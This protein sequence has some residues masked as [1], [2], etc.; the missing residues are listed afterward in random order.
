M[1][2]TVK[3]KPRSKQT[4]VKQVE[5]A[6]YEVAVHEAPAD[7]KANMA[8]QKAL[9]D[10]FEVARSRVSLVRGEGSRLKV[11]EIEK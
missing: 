6:M 8:I 4:S 11:F 1:R 2:I 10:H 5:G 7:G 3:A 9:A